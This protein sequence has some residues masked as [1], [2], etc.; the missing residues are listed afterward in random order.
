MP[1]GKLLVKV[2]EP[3]SDRNKVRLFDPDLGKVLWEQ[4][5][6]VQRHDWIESSA[7]SPDGRWCLETGAGTWICVWETQTGQP[8]VKL[9]PPPGIPVWA[10]TPDSRAIAVPQAAKI[11]TFELPSGKPLFERPLIQHEGGEVQVAAISP[12]GRSVAV[13]LPD[14]TYVCDLTDAASAPASVPLGRVHDIPG[15]DEILWSPSGKKIAIAGGSQLTI[16]SSDLQTRYATFDEPAPGMYMHPSAWSADEKQLAIGTFSGGVLVY[17]E[18]QDELDMFEG[19]AGSAHF[20]V[21]SPGQDQL[22]TNG[23]DGKV[24]FWDI[25]SKKMTR[26]VD[27]RTGYLGSSLVSTPRRP[28]APVW[29]PDGKFLAVFSVGEQYNEA[30]VTMVEVASGEVYAMPLENRSVGGNEIVFSPDSRVLAAA[31]TDPGVVLWNTANKTRITNFPD[32]AHASWRVEFSADS[33]RLFALIYDLAPVR[34]SEFGIEFR[35][36]L[37]TSQGPIGY[38]RNWDWNRAADIGIRTDS[39]SD[40]NNARR[41]H[42]VSLWRLSSGAPLGTIAF[43]R[44]TVLYVN[45]EGHYSSSRPID[46]DLVYQVQTDKGQESLTPAEFAQQYGWQNDPSRVVLAPAAPGVHPTDT[47]ARTT[48]TANASRETPSQPP[49]AT[50]VPLV[51]PPERPATEIGQPLSSEALVQQPARIPGVRG[52]TIETRGPRLGSYVTS[53]LKVSPDGTMLASGGMDGS[54]RL[55]EMATGRLVRVLVGANDYISTMAWSPDGKTLAACA[56][57]QVSLW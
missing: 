11:T 23:L 8:V 19:P 30:S 33:E 24:Y 5:S 16:R 12:D 3:D 14:K 40:G 35:R 6:P 27:A 57:N 28:T 9:P 36:L 26:S 18:G 47:S 48:D 31:F 55:W 44:D 22:A 34:V 45:A 56:G 50:P 2:W 25:A 52:W 42:A 53:I 39:R 46:D 20:P 7:F 38:C 15:L 32:G 37:R 51:I 49:K 10:W 1:D 41:I 29:S 43:L 13:G 17:T 54:V 4:V 21:W